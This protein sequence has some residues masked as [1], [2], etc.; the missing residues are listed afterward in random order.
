LFSLAAMRLGARRVHSFDFDPDSVACTAEL[1]RRYFPSAD[2]WSIESGSA[3]D[4]AYLERLGTWDLVYSWGVLHHTGDLWKA[5]DLVAGRVAPGGRLFIAIY[6]DQGP[7]SRFWTRVKRTYNKGPLRRNVLF[8]AFGVWWVVR[9]A[10]VD[11]VRRQN[12]VTR[13]RVYRNTR[14][15]SVV[16]DWRDW[17]GG[18]PFEVATPE[19]VLDF[20][21]A[22]G[23]S[24]IKL[25]T[26]G[27]KLGC[28]EFVFE[29]A[30]AT[31]R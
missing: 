25:K 17:L 24:L 9:G 28:N 12:P 27:G 29:R 14:G 23:F 31:C 10:A 20:C 3:L 26:C 5:L 13:Y 4:A 22:R 16:H 11:L 18:Y 2:H 15:M 19:A 30:G 21:R 8:G 6:N 1:R 7:L